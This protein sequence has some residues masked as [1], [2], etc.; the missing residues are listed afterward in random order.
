MKDPPTFVYPYSS[1]KL[2]Y[3]EMSA[4]S[5]I[6]RL[7]VTAGDYEKFRIGEINFTDIIENV[8]YVEL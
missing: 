4:Q 1:I 7:W 3:P 8:C 6:L 5:S 2:L